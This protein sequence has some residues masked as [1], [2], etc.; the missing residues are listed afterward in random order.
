MS[1]LNP[2][3]TA[4]HLQTLDARWE[5]LLGEYKT[6]MEVR[7]EKSRTHQEAY[8]TAYLTADYTASN[9]A[10]RRQSAIH[11]TL[12]ASE[13]LAAAEDE[14]EFKK[15]ELRALSARTDTARSLHAGVK[16]ATT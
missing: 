16:S 7:R 9:D 12:A 4:D 3:G 15:A 14:V 10:M 1:G 13:A 6:A 2:S 11:A 8:A 5:S